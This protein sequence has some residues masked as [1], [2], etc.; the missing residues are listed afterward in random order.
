MWNRRGARHLS[1]TVGKHKTRVASSVFSHEDYQIV[2]NCGNQLKSVCTATTPWLPFHCNPQTLNN[3]YTAKRRDVFGGW[4]LLD[5]RKSLGGQGCTTQ[6][7]P[8]PVFNHHSL[9]LV[10]I[11]P[12]SAAML[13]L[14]G[15]VTCPWSR[16][17]S[18]NNMCESHSGEFAV[19]SLLKI[20]LNLP[21][22]RVTV[23]TTFFSF[24]L[25]PMWNKAT[26]A[27][28]SLWP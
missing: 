13:T 24:I 16:N 17:I 3:M 8:P 14:F 11:N 6:Y 9:L 21:R 10:G 2:S 18:W 23:S 26:P 27:T 4:N 25:P 19:Y 20:N 5:L 28:S 15:L 12:S 1:R 7:I 22:M